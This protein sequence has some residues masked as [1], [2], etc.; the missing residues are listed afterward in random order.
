MLGSWSG[1]LL[2]NCRTFNENETQQ[3]SLLSKR[4]ESY[5][6]DFT[7][8]SSVMRYIYLSPNLSPLRR[9]ALTLAPFPRREGGWGLGLT[10]PHNSRNRCIYVLT[11]L[12]PRQQTKPTCVGYYILVGSSCLISNPFAL[13]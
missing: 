8:V 3:A 10:V 7:A 13:E 9:E 12:S 1:V 6:L 2:E 4:Y 5:V 11:G